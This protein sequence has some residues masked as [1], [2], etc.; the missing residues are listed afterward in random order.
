M[1]PFNAAVE[2]SFE[3]TLEVSGPVKLEVETGSGDIRIKAS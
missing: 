1:W 2:G 3:K